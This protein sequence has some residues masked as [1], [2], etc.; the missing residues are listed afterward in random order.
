MVKTRK[1]NTNIRTKTIITI[2]YFDKFILVD[3]LEE[4]NF[5]INFFKNFFYYKLINTL[6]QR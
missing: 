6:N 2:I 5:N 1:I 4:S 3:E